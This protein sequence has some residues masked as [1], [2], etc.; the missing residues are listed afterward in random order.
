MHGTTRPADVDV[1]RGEGPAEGVSRIRTVKIENF[2]SIGSAAVDLGP[3]TILVGVNGVGKSNFLDALRFVAEA[4]STSIDLAFKNRGGI[5]AVRRRS[6]GH[7]HNIG[8]RLVIDLASGAYAEYSLTIAAKAGERFEISRERCMVYPFLGERVGFD[9]KRDGFTRPIPGVQA[10]IGDDR[11]A[12]FAASATPE[13]RELYDFLVGINVYAI[14]PGELRAAQTP[15]S[16]DLLRPNGSNAA[17]VL[18]RLE[19]S[20][21]DSY[22][23]LNRLLSTAVPGIQSARHKPIGSYETI[24]FL[25]HVGLANPWRFDAQN[26]SDGTL[27]M[28]GVLLAVYQPGEASVLGIEEPETSVHPAVTEQIVEVLRD[29]SRRRQVI[30]TTHSPDL[31]DFGE[32]DAEWLRIVTK[33]QNATLIATLADSSRDAVK[34]HLYTS[35]ELLRSGELIGDTVAAGARAQQMK[36]FGAALGA[37]DGE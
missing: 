4:L 3:L 34:E 15:D 26:V 13:F 16:G 1:D 20:D 25:Q 29:A 19:D 35:G 14:A 5:A 7:P 9:R 10:R 6:G 31:L 32:V 28:L 8:F 27:R 17:A 11:L 22:E 36:L 33:H 30:A 23:R 24:E 2:K 18:K 12:L 37:K 21:A